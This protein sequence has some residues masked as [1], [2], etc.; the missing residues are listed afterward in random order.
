MKRWDRYIYLQWGHSEWKTAV[1]VVNITY[2]DL[3]LFEANRTTFQVEFKE[4]GTELEV[5][6]GGFYLVTLRFMTPDNQVFKVFERA[7]SMG[8]DPV[9]NPKVYTGNSILYH[10]PSE[11]RLGMIKAMNRLPPYCDLSNL[12]SSKP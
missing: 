1:D 7:V 11:G 6:Y 8:N 10:C 3:M 12:N 9:S 5:E 2:Y 4:N